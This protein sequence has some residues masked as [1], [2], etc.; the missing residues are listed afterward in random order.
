MAKVLPPKCALA[1]SALFGILFGCLVFRVVLVLSTSPNDPPNTFENSIGNGSVA[2][3]AAT[4]LYLNN[5]L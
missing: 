2:C 1:I 5:M 3:D 4:S